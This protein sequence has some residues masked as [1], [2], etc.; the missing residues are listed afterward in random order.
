MSATGFSG[1]KDPL[2]SLGGFA[3]LD[4]AS[5]PSHLACIRAAGAART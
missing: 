5:S 1:V 2:A 3:V 4:S